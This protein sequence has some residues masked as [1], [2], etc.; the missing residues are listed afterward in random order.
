M[1]KNR[2]MCVRGLEFPSETAFLKGSLFSAK[3]K[4]KSVRGVVES[5]EKMKKDYECLKL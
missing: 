5:L 4:L 2:K 3:M 1:S